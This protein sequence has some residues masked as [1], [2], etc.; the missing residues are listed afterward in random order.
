M[1]TGARCPP[2]N[3]PA[4][5][6]TS[7]AMVQRSFADA[8]SELRAANIPFDAPLRDFAYV[9]RNGQRIPI[10]GGPGVGAFNVIVT[11]FDPERGYPD[12]EHGTSYL[13]AVYLDGG[14]PEAYTLHAYSQSTDPGSPYYDDQTRLYSDKSWIRFPFCLEDIA[15]DPALRTTRIGGG[16]GAGQEPHA[17]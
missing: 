16:S 9:V 12:V 13:Q 10:H 4:K 1:E 15:S 6:N 14:C 3:T 7:D 5:L 17:P 2:V 11:P 8:V